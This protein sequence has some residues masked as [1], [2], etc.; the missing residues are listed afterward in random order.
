[1]KALERLARQ[2]RIEVVDLVDELA[3]VRER[4]VTMPEERPV[5]ASG[6]E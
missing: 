2:Q 1:M 6:K 5:A 3:V 4:Y